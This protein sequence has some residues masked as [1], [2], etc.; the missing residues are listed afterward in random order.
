MR[1]NGKIIQEL[2]SDFSGAGWNVIKVIWGA[3]WDPLLARDHD[4]ILLKRMEEAV[5]GEYQK[6]K[7]RDGAY[8]RENFFGK[9]PE[10]RE[11]VSTMSD[12]EIWRL[13]RGGHDPHKIYAAYSAAMKHEGQPTVI[14]AK[15]VKGYGMGA[16]GEGK[17][18]AHQQKKMPLEALKQFRDRFKIPVPDDRAGEDPLLPAGARL[19]GGEVPRRTCAPSWAG[20]C[21]SAGAR[22]AA[23]SRRPSPTR[24][25]RCSRR[26]PRA[27][28]SRPRWR[29]CGS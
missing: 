8:V 28:R 10:L 1:G 18:I 16:V 25:S 21:R 4:G 11:M 26:P 29:S 27:A 13:N 3:Y 14:L 23:S 15:T 20:R 12:E 2:E 17:N 5:D 24:S 19:G 6:F 9:Y 7:S 22:A